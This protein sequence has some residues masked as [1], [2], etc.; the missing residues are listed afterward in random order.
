MKDDQEDGEEGLKPTDPEEKLLH[1]LTMFLPFFKLKQETYLIGTMK[2]QVIVKGQACT[3]RTGG[4]YM[5]LEEFLR[6]YAKME[7]G[8]LYRMAKR[9]DCKMS[10]AVLDLLKKHGAS[11]KTIE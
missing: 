9:G 8:S 2:R 1:Q 3:V 10:T 7:C 5:Y 11:K 6:H 4:G